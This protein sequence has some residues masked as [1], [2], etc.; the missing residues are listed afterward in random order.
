M[1]VGRRGGI[2]GSYT[3]VAAAR[4]FATPLRP[5][6]LP[7]LFLLHLLVDAVCCITGTILL[8]GLGL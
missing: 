6:L 4:F 2:V 5:L 3:L 1:V 7:L 8:H